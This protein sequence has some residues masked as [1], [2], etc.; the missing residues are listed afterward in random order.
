MNIFSFI[1]KYNSIFD[2]LQSFAI[3]FPIIISIFAQIKA[4]N[5]EI[6][7]KEAQ[8]T[9]EKYN[10]DNNNLNVL[11]VPAWKTMDFIK[12]FKVYFRKTRSYREVDYI[13]FY[14]NWYIEAYAKFEEINFK[15]LDE[16]TK[17]KIQSF[18]EV[19][20]N[21]NSFYK[22]TEFKDIKYNWLE[23]GKFPVQNQQYISLNEITK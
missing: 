3:I 4:K 10:D 5:A 16:E 2:F 1:E 17:K 7:A 9:L 14:K 11:V 19:D 8:N 13:A 12:N 22:L 23:N 15:K 18:E 20:I 6:E 21:N